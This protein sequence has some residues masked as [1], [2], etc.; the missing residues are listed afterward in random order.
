VLEL[1]DLEDRPVHLDVVAVAEL[2]GA[3]HRRLRVAGPAC[4]S[5]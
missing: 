1:E 5:P 3:E 4:R 2:V